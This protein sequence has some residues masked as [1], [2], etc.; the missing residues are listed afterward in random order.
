[1]FSYSVAK[2]GLRQSDVVDE[3][4]GGV[5]YC[6]VSYSFNFLS[7]VLASFFFFRYYKRNFGVV[8]IY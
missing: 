2:R 6:T 7:W 8:K 3:A 1:M 5:E 4:Y